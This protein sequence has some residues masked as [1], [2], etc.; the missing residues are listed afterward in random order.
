[1]VL[2]KNVGPLAQSAEGFLGRI[3]LIEEGIPLSFDVGI[4]WCVAVRSFERRIELSLQVLEKL[5][6]DCDRCL[7]FAGCW[8]T[9]GASSAEICWCSAYAIRELHEIPV[10]NKTLRVGEHEDA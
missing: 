9:H 6:Q 4:D 5:F 2:P 7:N 10:Y 1:M 3:E 8:R